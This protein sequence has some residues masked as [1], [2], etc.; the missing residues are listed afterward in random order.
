MRDTP[1]EPSTPLVPV[2]VLALLTLT[3]AVAVVRIHR[4]RLS[5]SV[6]LTERPESPAAPGRA[7]AL[8]EAELHEMIAESR[9]RTLL[10]QAADEQPEHAGQR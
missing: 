1:S 10:G 8:I 7:D 4:R 5:G 2:L 3:A 6:V 9:A